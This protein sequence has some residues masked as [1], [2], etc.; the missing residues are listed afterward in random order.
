MTRL[1]VSV[2]LPLA[3][4]VGAAS[5]DA[6][7]APPPAARDGADVAALLGRFACEPSVRALQRA[8]AEQALVE[9]ERPRAALRRLRAS[10]LLP[11]LRVRATRGQ[12]GLTVARGADGLDAVSPTLSDSWRI[13]VEGTFALDRLLFDRAEVGLAR[14]HQRLAARREALLTEVAQLYFARRRLQ[15][16]ALLQPEAAPVDAAERALA[17][18]ELTAVLDGLTDGALTRGACREER[19]PARD[20]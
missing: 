7:A 19:S 9:P 6:L 20:P 13:E 17:I 11:T 16:A 2:A 15:V 5:A 12:L 3:L 10:A 14:E 8:A 1:A 4:A 18:D